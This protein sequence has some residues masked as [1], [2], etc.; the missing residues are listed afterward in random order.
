MCNSE[1]PTAFVYTS[2]EWWNTPLF[3]YFFLWNFGLQLSNFISCYFLDWARHSIHTV[4]KSIQQH[5][6]LHQLLNIHLTAMS[7]AS[8]YVWRRNLFH[9]V[10][11]YYYKTTW[12]HEALAWTSAIAVY[13]CIIQVLCMPG[14]CIKKEMKKPVCDTRAQDQKKVLFTNALTLLQVCILPVQDWRNAGIITREAIYLVAFDLGIIAKHT[15][16]T[17]NK[18]SN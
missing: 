1:L 4:N 16:T 17:N 18:T 11:G 3:Y 5:S 13:P 9:L 10:F 2:P 8:C 6:C 7:E 15:I 14:L 12:K